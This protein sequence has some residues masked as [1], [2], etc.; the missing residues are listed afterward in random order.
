[1]NLSGRFSKPDPGQ[2][3][4]WLA[5]AQAAYKAGQRAEALELL[6]Q[7][8]QMEEKNPQAWLLLSRLVPDVDDKIIALENALTLDPTRAQTRKLLVQM[9]A[10]RHS[11]LELGKLY[12]HLGDHENAIHQYL[13]ARTQAETPAERFEIRRCL[14]KAQNQRDPPEFK[15]VDPALTWLRLSIGP[16]LLYGGWLLIHSGLNLMAISPLLCL[17][18]LG[19]ILGSVLITFTRCPSVIL[20]WRPWW[21]DHLDE[22]NIGPARYGAWLVGLALLLAPYLLL[23]L[24]AWGRVQPAWNALWP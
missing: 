16:V 6:L 22:D 18:G 2:A 24:D 7:Y 20:A 19:V 13:I 23:L 14:E 21:I 12:E 11:P 15:D 4:Q 17:G 8:V 5:Q 3:A 10:A 1:M 9:R